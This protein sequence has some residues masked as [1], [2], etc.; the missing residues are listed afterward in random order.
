MKR[1]QKFVKIWWK[2]LIQDPSGVAGGPNIVILGGG[3]GLAVALRGLKK[4]STNITAVVTMSDDGAS[5]GKLRDEMGILP[6][7]D[8]RKCIASLADEEPLLTKLFE[9]RFK[10]GKSLSGHSFGNLFLAAMTDISGS[11]EEAVAQTSRI[12]AISGQVMPATLA[13]V[14]L[15]AELE[16]GNIIWG[17]SKIPLHAHK[18]PVKKIML[19]PSKIR[20]FEPVIETIKKADIIIIGP[21]SLYTSIV[22]NL[23]I[24]EIRDSIS[25]S[26]ASK[27]Y[28]CNISTERGETENMGVR[29]HLEIIR[30]YGGSKICNKILINSKII[31]E[32][33]EGE[34]GK[35][36]NISLSSDKL[37]KIEVYTTDL[38]NPKNPLYHDSTKLAQAIISFSVKKGL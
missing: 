37:Q 3:S 5:T 19:K 16:N 20:P 1:L 26:K 7:G 9:Y 27:I 33:Q 11:F 13:N 4:Y 18:S 35:I 12:L 2:S 24:K 32:E 8:I 38:I 6:P 22:P 34:L 25:F 36:K 28:V 15:G 17:E 23:L 29:E 30:K 10:N 31:K 14:T 21:G